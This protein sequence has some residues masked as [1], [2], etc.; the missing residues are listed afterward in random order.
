MLRTAEAMTCMITTNLHQT[1]VEVVSCAMFRA[2]LI[3]AV[4]LIV[5]FPLRATAAPSQLL[6]CISPLPHGGLQ[7]EAIPSGA[8]YQLRGN[9][10][11]LTQ[12]IHHLVRITGEARA[13][14]RSNQ[15]PDLT[16]Q[17]S[18]EV[19]ADSCAA[20]IHSGR[21]LAITGKVGAGQ[22]A[23][24]ITTTAAPGEVTPGA[25]TE[26]VQAQGEPMLTGRL[27]PALTASTR[28]PY[29]PHNVAQAAQTQAAA[30]RHAEAA[31]RS[32]IQPGNTIRTFST[33]VTAK[34]ITK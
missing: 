14:T 25:Q 12:G 5:G 21:L 1:A 8:S 34:R 28:A 31:Q 2:L 11:L 13:V 15:L 18:V 6:G 16:V 23:V 30:E 17:S 29:S 19:I 24:P 27:N 4:A 26:A 3:P 7:F 33:G 22:D 9:T 10:A 32:E 20:P